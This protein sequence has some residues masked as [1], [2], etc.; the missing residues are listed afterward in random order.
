MRRATWAIALAAVTVIALTT[1]PA[2]A[3]PEKFAR[4]RIPV[5]NG[6]ANEYSPAAD[7]AYVSWTASGVQRLRRYRVYFSVDGGPRQRANPPG[8]KAWNG[9]IDGTRLV[10]YRFGG[11]VSDLVLYDMATETELPLPAGVNTA[12][13]EHSPTI[14]GDYLLFDRED[15]S[16]GTT[17]QDIVLYNTSTDEETLLAHTESDEEFFQSGQVNGNWA[18]Y[19]Q[20]E[21]SG[22]CD[23]FRYDIGGETTVTVPN[24][25]LQQYS[26]SVTE[27]GTVYFVRS[28]PACGQ[29]VRYMVWDGASAPTRFNDFRPRRDS[30]DSFYDD[31][32]DSL[33]FEK[34]RCADGASGIF[35]KPAPAP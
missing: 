22:T 12:A 14:F 35:R 17:T 9:G 11:G 30:F 1:I 20:C 5:V 7:G 3:L 29:A 18:V 15:S 13:R 32:T 4:P 6:R 31:A 27:D 25:G 34:V 26:P 23:V 21:S 8:I 16:G 33:Y 24:P 19:F 2:S 10:Y 28:Q